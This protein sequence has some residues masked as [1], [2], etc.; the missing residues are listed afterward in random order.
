M[1]TLKPLRTVDCRSER[2]FMFLSAFPRSWLFGDLIIVS[3]LL[4]DTQSVF[5]LITNC[6]MDKIGG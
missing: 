5:I 2:F 6:S 4:K 1:N 3:K